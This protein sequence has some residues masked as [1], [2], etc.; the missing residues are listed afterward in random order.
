MGKKKRRR[1]KKEEKNNYSRSE[2]SSMLL[3]LL[4]SLVLHGSSGSG[5]DCTPPSGATFSMIWRDI[6]DPALGAD[7]PL[8]FDMSSS[9]D[10][11]GDILLKI[12]IHRRHEKMLLSST[13][14]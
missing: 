9:R 11:S 13:S 2:L 12:E 5:G 8:L 4:M 10:S 7:L 14:S 1:E 3:M 6:S